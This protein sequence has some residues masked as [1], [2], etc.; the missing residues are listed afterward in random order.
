MKDKS[1]FEYV[2]N[3][4]NKARKTRQNGEINKARE[5]LEKGLDQYPENNYLK[6]SLAD[7]YLYLDLLADAELLADEVL[8]ER[9]DYALALTVKGSLM[10]KKNNYQHA[11]EFFKQSLEARDSSYT[12][13]K[14]ID[15]Y[16]KLEEYE[17]ALSLCQERLEQEPDNRYLLQKKGRIYEMMNKVKDA[18]R[19]YEDYLVE[20]PGN[21]FAYKKKIKLKLADKEP[22]EKIKEIKQLIKYGKDKYQAELYSLLAENLVKI[23]KLKEAVTAYKGALQIKPGDQYL[24]KQIG[25]TL[26]K[27]DKDKE[28]L[29]YLKKVFE[30]EPNN[31]YLKRTLP[32]IYKKLGRE[33]EGQKFIINIINSKSGYENLWGLVN[34]LSKKDGQKDTEDGVSDGNN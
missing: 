18:T 25:F 27:M 1:E 8:K 17:Q 34:S 10:A 16:I 11:L 29:P 4:V 3:L 33:R 30:N 14:I 5:M 6:V 2:K 15:M 32:A 22:A 21:G 23:D 24:L 31:N 9:P 12:V 26:Y 20:D 7:I 19:I 13:S 28:A